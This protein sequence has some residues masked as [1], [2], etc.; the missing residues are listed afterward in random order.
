[1]PPPGRDRR[2]AIM[3]VEETTPMMPP[4]ASAQPVA[5]KS[6]WAQTTRLAGWLLYT[7]RRR[8][9]G[10]VLLAILAGV[11]L[12]VVG[13][14]VVGYVVVSNS[15]P[16]GTACVQD[17][18]SAKPV[19]QP[20]SPDQVAQERQQAI[21]RVRA[22]L[23][24]PT[25]LSIVAVLTGLLG[26]IVLTTLAGM[27]AGGEYG[28][29]TVRVIL[30]RGVGRGQFVLAQAAALAVLALAAA[31]LMVLLGTLVGFTIGPLL[32]GTLPAL[33]TGAIGEVLLVWLALAVQ[34]FGYT[35][36]AL[37]MATLG[38][39]T[40]AGIGF[41]LGYFVAEGVIGGLLSI[42]ALLFATHPNIADFIRHI[43]DWFFG[44]NASYLIG[45]VGQSPLS[46]APQSGPPGFDLTH[47]LVV[48][49][50]YF[51][52]TIGGSYALVRRRDITD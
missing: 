4:P 30:A 29:G 24:F 2:A 11:F 25:P 52:L 23:T 35:S 16:S 34:L 38:R 27:M 44:N 3:I 28:Y 49:V 12:L 41:G 50:L 22:T 8:A 47:A 6:W 5:A 42:V 32:G 37:F 46:I 20:L 13:L 10:K 31:A 33:T 21:D 48:M 40:A 1:P 39:S 36:I 14:Q 43:P 15:T 45:R 18:P 51:V 26:V 19:C 9:S 17:S 7:W